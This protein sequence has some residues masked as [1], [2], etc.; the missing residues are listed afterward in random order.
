MKTSGRRRFFTAAT[1]L[2]TPALGIVCAVG[3]DKT[4][5][6]D[7]ARQSTHIRLLSV[8][9]K[10]SAT[11][12]QIPSSTESVPVEEGDAGSSIPSDASKT[13]LS[14]IEAIDQS[15]ITNPDLIAARQQ[16]GVGQAIVGVA[17]KYPF[18]PFLQT[19][20][21][22]WGQRANGNSASVYRYVL[23]SQ[24]FELAHQQRF[25]KQNAMAALNDVRWTI[26]QTELVSVAQTE[27]LF[28]TAL[29][30]KALWQLAVVNTDVVDGLLNII[31]RQLKAGAASASDVSIA[32]IDA[33]SARQQ[34]KLAEANYLTAL[35]AVRRQLN[36]PDEATI[37]VRGELDQFQWNETNEAYA[38]CL[39]K[40][41]IAKQTQ[42]KLADE[43]AS[44]RPDVLAAESRVSAF[45][46]NLSLAKANRVPNLMAGPF[47]SQDADIYY[48]G[49]QAQAD[50][51]IVNGGKPLVGQRNAEL[52]QQQVVWE[53]LRARARIEGLTAIERY[54][55]AR[56]LLDPESTKQSKEVPTELQKLDELYKRGEVDIL[57]VIQART[58]LL[59]LR[60]AQ[61]D[62]LNEV[63]QA[64][65]NVTQF[66]GLRPHAMVSIR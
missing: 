26:A 62:I 35:E 66:T 58:S 25:R 11:A 48:I 17:Q 61:L 29:Y 51:P 8:Q 6:S 34:Q 28:F 16:E 37:D 64:S 23:F 46:A 63:A 24:T 21:L 43:L 60:R 57:R 54:E 4:P 30:Q 31:E 38:Y 22:P 44:I 3:E 55:R 7:P 39:E 40:N 15:L 14:L 36:L 19:R 5:E 20:I 47:Y 33:N 45:R 49:F 1:I 53:Q 59:Q 65:A 56:E 42:K 9:A 32:R 13:S 18:N 27:R 12:I 41:E 50:V 52:R 2:A 10:D